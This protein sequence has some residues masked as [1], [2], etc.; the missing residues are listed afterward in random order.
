MEK[1]NGSIVFPFRTGCN[2]A[3]EIKWGDNDEEMAE[4]A[5]WPA[6]GMRLYAGFGRGSAAGKN[7]FQHI[8]GLE[9]GGEAYVDHLI[10]NEKVIVS[11]ENAQIIFVNC[12]C[13]ADLV[14][15]AEQGTRVLLLGCDVNGQTYSMADCEFFSDLTAPESGLVAYEGQEASCYCIARWQENGQ[16]MQMVICELDPSM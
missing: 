16:Q 12:E 13:N 2:A 1:T 9:D 7:V 5:A 6:D 11:G 4:F 3:K 15:T 10:F 8:Y 14:L